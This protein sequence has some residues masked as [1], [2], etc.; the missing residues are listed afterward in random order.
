[1]SQVVKCF[2]LLFV[3]TTFSFKA[4]GQV[5]LDPP[6]KTTS[7][8]SY[9]IQSSLHYFEPAS[10]LG[11]DGEQIPYTDNED[12]FFLEGDVGISYGWSRSME[13]YGGARLRFVES[14]DTLG[15]SVSNSGLES[16]VV[17]LKYGLPSWTDGWLFS[18][19]IRYRHTAYDN[20]EYDPGDAP[21]DEIILGDNGSAFKLGVHF[22]KKEFLLGSE[23]RGSFFYHRPP[24]NLSQEIVYD[25]SLNWGYE[26]WLVAGGIEGIYSLGLDDF[27]VSPETKPSMSTGNTFLFNSINRERVTPYLAIGRRFGPRSFASFKAGQT[28]MGK[29]TDEGVHFLLS[30]SWSSKG[31]EDRQ[32][33]VDSFKEYHLEAS[34]L[35]VSPRGAFVQIDKGLGQDVDKGMRFDIFQ[36]GYFGENVLVASGIVYEVSADTAIIRLQQRYSDIE[37]KSGFRARGR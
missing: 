16:I 25:F 32:L 37:I 23:V 5:L 10:R 14:M 2:I 18:L 11:L 30:I 27:E 1:M 15:D 17:G 6:A 7:F 22:A 3:L 13:I 26:K 24:N 35:K 31:T 12:Y 8:E 28:V 19:D 36:S 9:S 33:K 4:P 34:V 29:S 21:V 20:N